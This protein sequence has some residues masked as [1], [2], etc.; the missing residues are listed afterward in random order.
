MSS[1]HSNLC[2]E[3]PSTNLTSFF[4][5]KKKKDFILQK[6]ELFWILSWLVN[7]NLN[8]NDLDQSGLLACL[9]GTALT[10]S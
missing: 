3:L 8:F 6:F 4:I 7:A 1:K 9:W 2:F 5:K 10:V